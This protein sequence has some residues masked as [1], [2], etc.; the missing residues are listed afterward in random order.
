SRG[1]RPPRALSVG[2]FRVRGT[3]RI[4]LLQVLGE[5]LGSALEVG[6]VPLHDDVLQDPVEVADARRLFRGVVEY[7]LAHHPHPARVSVVTLAL[8]P[9]EDPAEVVRPFGRLVVPEAERE[10]DPARISV[11]ELDRLDSPEIERFPEGPL[12]RILDERRKE[13]LRRVDREVDAD[14]LELV[15]DL[16][17]VLE[18]ALVD[19]GPVGEI[20]PGLRPD[21]AWVRT[22]SFFK[23]VT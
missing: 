18:E 17:E 23:D 10:P 2:F 5:L 9:L 8:A 16:P 3:L 12:G 20:F 19:L 14:L 15:M 1:R 22:N 11:R 21:A 7:G 6:R 4:L 13:G